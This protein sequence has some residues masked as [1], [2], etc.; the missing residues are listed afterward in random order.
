MNADVDKGTESGHVGH[1]SLQDHTFLQVADL[2][3]I[4]PEG[5]CLEPAARVAPRFLQLFD[6]VVQGRQTGTVSHITFQL[7]P[8]DQGR[9][10]GQTRQGDTQVGGHGLHQLVALGMH[11]GVVQRM[12]ATPDTQKPGRLLEGLGA[13]NNHKCVSC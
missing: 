9:I 3:D 7:Y 11:S 4:I 10:G 2:A 5:C 1:G 6:D 8:V 12:S 13:K